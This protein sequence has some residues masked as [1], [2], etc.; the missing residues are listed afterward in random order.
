M[1]GENS[2]IGLYRPKFNHGTGP[3]S[4]H[5]LAEWD[6]GLAFKNFNFTDRGF[7]VVKIAEIKAGIGP[8]TKFTDGTYNARALLQ[9]G[10]LLFCWSGQPET[11][12]GTFRWWHGP[13]WLNQHVFKVTPS[14]RVSADYLRHLLRYLQPQFVQIAK[15]KQTTGLG[16]VTKADLRDMLVEVPE[17]TIQ[18]TISAALNPIDDKIELNRR[19]TATLEEMAQALFKS[20]F[21]DFDPVRAKAEGRPTGLSDATAALFPSRF[22]DDG[23]PEGWSA[24]ADSI[25]RNV[26]EQVQPSD[27]DANTPYV[28]LDHVQKRSLALHVAGRAEDVDSQK[29]VFKRGDLLFG[30]LRPYFHKV[31]VAPIDGICSTD[32]FVFRPQKG[33]PSTYLYLAFSA[34]GFVAKASGAQEGTRMPRAD[35]GFMRKLAMAKPEPQILTA[36]DNVVAP[37]IDRILANVTQTQSLTFLRDTLLPKLISGE[38]RINYAKNAVEAA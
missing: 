25:G 37:L 35:W 16:H 2:D 9:D 19:M 6:N 36:F 24:T 34:D 15:N 26:R 22:G 21:V 30:K 3:C 38:L 5:S 27:V 29:A 23:M 18:A 13:A 11:S 14:K 10:D 17:P 28:G 7:P 1:A 4:L 12:I 32:I 31:A 33:I 20:W 8:D